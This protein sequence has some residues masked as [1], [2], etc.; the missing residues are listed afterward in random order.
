MNVSV[1]LLAYYWYTAGRY[2]PFFKW[3][4]FPVQCHLQHSVAVNIIVTVMEAQGDTWFL[5]SFERYQGLQ[6]QPA[7]AASDQVIHDFQVESQ[8]SGLHAQDGDPTGTS[9][10]TTFLVPCLQDDERLVEFLDNSHMSSTGSNRQ[11]ERLYCQ[12]LLFV[13]RVVLLLCGMNHDL[14]L[15]TW[16]ELL[17]REVENIWLWLDGDEERINACYTSFRSDFP[18]A[19][20]EWKL[21]DSEFLMGISSLARRTKCVRT[22]VLESQHMMERRNR[23][24]ALP[25][26]DLR[27]AAI[28]WSIA[29]SEAIRRADISRGI[30]KRDLHHRLGIICGLNIVTSFSSAAKDFMKSALQSS[31]FLCYKETMIR[32][33]HTCPISRFE[34]DDFYD[35]PDYWIYVK[36]LVTP[37]QELGD[38]LLQGFC[39]PA[40]GKFELEFWYEV[41]IND[42]NTI[43]TI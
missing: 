20:G 19:D 4:V 5:L 39:S 33:G 25:Y 1:V 40:C 6:H 2:G 22:G 21:T 34:F 12:R 36:S 43:L 9:Q 35:R 14:A 17:D 10:S 23:L 26:P 15:R 31:E 41:L 32:A 30:Q 37:N 24:Y 11:F 13:W 18:S 38:T 8:W 29:T 27:F 28:T 3:L 42:T 16:V 7:V